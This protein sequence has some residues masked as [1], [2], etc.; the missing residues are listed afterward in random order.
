VDRIFEDE[1]IDYNEKITYIYIPKEYGF[2]VLE[3]KLV[4][5]I[6]VE[7][8]TYGD[9]NQITKQEIIFKIPVTLLFVSDSLKW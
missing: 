7:A 5:K 2:M 1:T 6:N 4:I 8:S 3:D 9:P